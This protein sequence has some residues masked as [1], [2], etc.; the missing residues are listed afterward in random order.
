VALAVLMGVLVVIQTY[1]WT[2]V[3]P[4]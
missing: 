4:G 2:S 3:V 1:L